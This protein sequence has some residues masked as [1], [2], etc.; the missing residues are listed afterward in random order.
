LGR[1]RKPELAEGQGKADLHHTWCPES[2]SSNLNAV[3]LVTRRRTITATTLAAESP[4]RGGGWVDATDPQ[5]HSATQA[6]S[7]ASVVAHIV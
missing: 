1:G 3:D 4:N 5:K 7:A 2:R 6:V